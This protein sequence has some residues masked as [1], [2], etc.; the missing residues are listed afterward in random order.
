M[1]NAKNAQKARHTKLE[2]RKTSDI[3]QLWHMDLI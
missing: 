3:L 2:S 1:H